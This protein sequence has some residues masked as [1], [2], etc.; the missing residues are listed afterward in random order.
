[1]RHVSIVLLLAF[2]FLGILAMGVLANDPRSVEALITFEGTTVTYVGKITDENV[3]RLFEM[4]TGRIVTELIISTSGGEINAGM[5]MGEWVFDNKI[6]V[7]VE[8]MCLS[9]GANYVF[10]AGRQ[11]IIKENSIVGWHGSALQ[12]SGLFADD[13]REATTTAYGQLPEEIKAQLDLEVLVNQSIRDHEE[14]LS[15]S[16]VRQAQFFEKIGI[17]EYVTRIGNE[18]YGAKD[19]FTMSVEDMARFGMRNVIA[20]GN[21]GEVDSTTWPRGLSVDFIH[22]VH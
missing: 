10:T 21:Y 7:V 15:R 22:I 17:D 9:S 8:G 2:L 12:Q 13:I 18:Q 1:M 11:K 14:Y 3:Q 6:D 4:V 20:Q 16:K 5:T 19:F